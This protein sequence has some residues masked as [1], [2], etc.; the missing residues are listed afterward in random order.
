MHHA[1]RVLP[2]KGLVVKYNDAAEVRV[3]VAAVIATAA[4]AVLVTQHLPKLGADLVTARLV[5]EIAWRQE[6]CG[7]N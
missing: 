4:D 6:A 2:V 7:G 1:G 3:L 5:K